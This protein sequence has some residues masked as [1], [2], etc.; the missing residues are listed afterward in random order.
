VVQRGQQLRAED[1]V[2]RRPT[3]GVVHLHRELA[4]M[5]QQQLDGARRLVPRT[6]G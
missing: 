4:A 2:R 5:L 3:L 6:T 1:V